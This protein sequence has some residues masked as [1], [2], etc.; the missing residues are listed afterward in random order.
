MVWT[1]DLFHPTIE[2]FLILDIFI[3]GPSQLPEHHAE[4]GVIRIYPLEQICRS[5]FIHV[6]DLVYSSEEVVVILARSEQ[7]CMFQCGIYLSCTD[8]C[9]LCSL[10]S[11]PNSFIECELMLQSLEKFIYLLKLIH[12]QLVNGL[13]F[14]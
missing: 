14:D 6:N 13:T 5:H 2:L 1:E 11:G 3:K 10:C 7:L 12:A 9:S 8:I 4:A